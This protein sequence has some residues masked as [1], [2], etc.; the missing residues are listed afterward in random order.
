M[1]GRFYIACYSSHHTYIRKGDAREE[2]IQH[3]VLERKVRREKAGT[4]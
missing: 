3:T 2:D 4:M 1:K